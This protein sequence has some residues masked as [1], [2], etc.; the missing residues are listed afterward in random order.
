MELSYNEA[1]EFF[2]ELVTENSNLHYK[3]HLNIL[4]P[5]TYT[6]K[7]GHKYDKVTKGSS[8]YCFVEKATGNVY[9]PAGWRAPY[10]KGNNPVRGNIFNM[11]S[12]ENADPYGSWLYCR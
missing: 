3:T 2:L 7:S 9:K 5:P 8:V 12:Y 11:T 1:M 6:I 4:T 10:T